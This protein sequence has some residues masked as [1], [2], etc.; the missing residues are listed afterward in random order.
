MY[1]IL[2]S[3]EDDQETKDKKMAL[4]Y[5]SFKLNATENDKDREAQAHSDFT[6]AHSDFTKL[7]GQVNEKLGEER[8]NTREEQR[9]LRRESESNMKAMLEIGRSLSGSKA[10]APARD[11]T[12]NAKHAANM[13]M[14][15]GNLFA[16]D[17]KMPATEKKPRTLG[18]KSVSFKMTNAAA[19]TW[20][21]EAGNLF[22]PDTKMPAEATKDPTSMHQFKFDFDGMPCVPLEEFQANYRT[23]DADTG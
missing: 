19:N 14:L 8:K 6:K 16:P 2:G 4:L 10:P 22:A 5:T 15:A 11:D 13:D 12:E 7:L 21:M 18:N 20:V 17:T 3:E 23:K 1:A 9:A